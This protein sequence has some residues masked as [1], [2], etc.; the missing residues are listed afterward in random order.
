[1][2]K[3]YDSQSIHTPLRI[4]DKLSFLAE[5]FQSQLLSFSPNLDYHNPDIPEWRQDI[6]NVIKRALVKVSFSYFC[7]NLCEWRKEQ[8]ECDLEH[9]SMV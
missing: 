5:Y 4:T 1:M 8:R 6:G 2:H 9:I 7:L 3:D